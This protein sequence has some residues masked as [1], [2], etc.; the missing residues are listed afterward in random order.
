M[1]PKSKRSADPRIV[2]NYNNKNK[3]NENINKLG[4]AKGSYEKK[5]IGRGGSF[6]GKTEPMSQR[7]AD[8]GIVA[9]IIIIRIRI[10]KIIIS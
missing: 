5:L 4:V 10:I 2:E 7:S 1:K 6:G 8:P 3:N 9:E